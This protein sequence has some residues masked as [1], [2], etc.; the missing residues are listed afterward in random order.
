MLLKL[1]DEFFREVDF[2]PVFGEPLVEFSSFSIDILD[3]I[4][5]ED[6]AEFPVSVRDNG[7]P[8]KSLGFDELFPILLVLNYLCLKNSEEKSPFSLYRLVR[9]NVTPS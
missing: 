8:L 7:D 2:D 4:D 9:I 1:V 3:L 5:L 6:F